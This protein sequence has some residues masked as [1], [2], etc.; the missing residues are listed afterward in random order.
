MGVQALRAQRSA[1]GTVPEGIELQ[2]L[3]D[4]RDAACGVDYSRVPVG[5]ALG[6][7]GQCWKE[8]LGEQEVA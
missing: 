1:L 6:A 2:S 8:Q 5:R 3:G 4:I 7:G